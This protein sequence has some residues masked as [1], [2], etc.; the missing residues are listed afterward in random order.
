MSGTGVHWGSATTT[1][2]WP[3]WT[4]IA[5]AGA[6]LTCRGPDEVRLGRP[7]PDEP[8]D[9]LVVPP[10]AMLENLRR[11]RSEHAV[12]YFALLAERLR[13]PGL[14]GPIVVAVSA[15]AGA[16]TLHRLHE[17]LTGE[18]RL[19][20]TRVVSAP[21]AALA[22]AFR[23]GALDQAPISAPVIVVDI[24]E[25]GATVT[26]THGSAGRLRPI[27]TTPVACPDGTADRG[28]IVGRAVAAAAA[29]AGLTG[30]PLRLLVLGDAALGRGIAAAAH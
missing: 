28:G 7:D 21:V 8:G 12:R 3:G 4:D 10:V 26:V 25:D 1:V 17:V 14:E 30:G 9:L 29:D 22:Q 18:V 16:E 2:A 11:G 6:G 23:S 15:R 20:V 13:E 24:D 19:P 27:F 5:E